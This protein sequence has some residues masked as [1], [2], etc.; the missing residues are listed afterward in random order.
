MRRILKHASQRRGHERFAE[1]DDIAKDD[2]AALFQMP[3]RDANGRR[4]KVKQD[5]THIRR[6]GELVKGL[7]ALP[8]PG[9]KPS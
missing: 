7:R 8:R 4:L 9:G 5:T 3:R 6:D 2:A 1:A